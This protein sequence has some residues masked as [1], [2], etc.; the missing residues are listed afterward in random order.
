MGLIVLIVAVVVVFMFPTLRCVLSHPLSVAKC[1]SLDLYH[2]LV[3]KG[4][5]SCPTGE[6]VAFVGLFGKGK[7]LSAVH[8]VVSMYERYNGVKV[9]CG[10]RKKLVTQR[11]KVLS[12][13]SLKI[14]YEDFVSL[15]QIVLCA[16][17]NEAFDDEHDTLTVTLVLGDEFSVQMNSRSFKTNIDPLFLNTLL[18][19]RHYH[20]SLYYTSQRFGHVDALLRQVT[21][22]VVDCDK[23]WRFQRQNLYD[24]WE[25]ENA[26]NTML[27]TP[28]ARRC[29]FVRNRDYEAYNTLA[30]VGNLKKSMQAGDMM[31]EEQ[32]L[33]LQQN[34]QSNMEGIAKPS[35]RWMKNRKQQN[36]KH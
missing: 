19:C 20:I 35:K 22:Y 33:A 31:T 28:I 8:K 25:L 16:E 13:V 36:R 34:Q 30:C 6:L 9:W 17:R 11:V 29:W 18:T 32:I 24:A 23:P 12:N 26:T 27:L 5:N 15:E 14:P 10:R 21:S 2:Y 4:G 3:H 7:T 1:G